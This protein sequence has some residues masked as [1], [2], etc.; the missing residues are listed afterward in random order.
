MSDSETQSDY[1]IIETKIDFM[2]KMLDD[3]IKNNGYPTIKQI[4]AQD[5]KA[6]TLRQALNIVLKLAEGTMPDV[7]KA[8]TDDPRCFK[9]INAI[10]KVKNF[11]QQL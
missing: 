4:Q 7:S 3:Y 8:I 1:K 5:P 11:T 10:T 2:E 6:M 9:T